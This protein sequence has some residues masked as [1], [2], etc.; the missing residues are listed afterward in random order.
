MTVYGFTIGSQWM[1]QGG[2]RAVVVDKFPKWEGMR[3]WHSY[4]N[5]CLLHNPTGRYILAED[6]Y[7]LTRPWTA[8]DEIETIEIA[9]VAVP[10]PTDDIGIPDD[11]PRYVASVTTEN[12]YSWLTMELIHGISHKLL[13]KNKNSAKRH[14]Y[15]LIK[16]SGGRPKFQV[17]I[18]EECV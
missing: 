9:G 15:A 5:E 3:V 8:A 11:Q 6:G 2:H 13:H 18:L 14:S 12:G 7:G 1:T 16:A 17:P 4:N 10:R